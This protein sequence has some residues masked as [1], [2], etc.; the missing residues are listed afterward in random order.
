MQSAGISP[1]EDIIAPLIQ[2]SGTVI[3]FSCLGERRHKKNGFA[4]LYLDNKPAGA[5]GNWAIQVK[6]KWSADGSVIHTSKSKISSRNGWRKVVN[7][8]KVAANEPPRF[9]KTGQ[10]MQS[11]TENRPAP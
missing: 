3:R 7:V 11:T 2:R 10:N 5:F 4:V 8:G 6:G 9:F 1:A